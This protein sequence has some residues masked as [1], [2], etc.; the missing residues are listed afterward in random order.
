[1]DAGI[2]IIIAVGSLWQIISSLSTFGAI[3]LVILAAMSIVSWMVIFRKFRQ[4]KAIAADSKAFMTY[5]RRA[6]RLE[7]VAGQAQ[8]YKNSPM[9]AIL[10]AWRMLRLDSASL[11]ALRWSR[12]M[13]LLNC[14]V[15]R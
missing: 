15:R 9:A 5:F 12:A 10:L 13:T 2:P 8:S 7:E 4:F 1:M 11:S 3:I 14:S 6:R